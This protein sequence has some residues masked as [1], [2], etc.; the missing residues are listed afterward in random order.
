[1]RNLFIAVFILLALPVLGFAA[2]YTV[3]ISPNY[4]D[5]GKV[6]RDSAS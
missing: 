1:M 4:I 6:A 5:L 2:D 3:G